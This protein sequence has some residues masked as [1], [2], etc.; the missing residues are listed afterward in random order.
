MTK[1]FLTAV[2]KG[3]EV[4]V[5]VSANH[6]AFE[7]DAGVCRSSAL[8]ALA[9]D[10]DTS[11]L[12]EGNGN[13]SFFYSADTAFALGVLR[14]RLEPASLR[15][16][17]YGH[18]L[19][20]IVYFWD[21]PTEHDVVAEA[22]R[23]HTF[24]RETWAVDQYLLRL[25]PV[26]TLTE[27]VECDGI[28]VPPGFDS[29]DEAM[30]L[31][32]SSSLKTAR[33]YASSYVR[34][35][36]PLLDSVAMT[37]ASLLSLLATLTGNSSA[38]DL[39]DALSEEQRVVVAKELASLTTPEAQLKRARM[40][41][42][43]AVQMAAILRNM[44]AQAFT[45]LPTILSSNYES[46]DYS[47]LGFGGSFLGYLALYEHTRNAFAELQLDYIVKNEFPTMTA[48]ALQ[49][50]RTSYPQWRDSLREHTG[51][52]KSTL[53]PPP[54]TGHHLLYFSNRL[55]FRET[56]LSMSAAYLSLRLGFLPSW[57]LFT[58]THEFMH[59][60]ARAFFAT[61]VPTAPEDFNAAYAA[62]AARSDRP[63]QSLKLKVFLQAMLLDTAHQLL[64]IDNGAG[65]TDGNLRRYAVVKAYP[66]KEARAF[67]RSS[68]HLLNE[69][70][71]SVLD[72]NYF[73]ANDP[74]LYVKS[75]WSSWLPLPIVFPRTFEYLLRTLC[76]ISSTRSGD[77]EEKFKWA[78]KVLDDALG[79]LREC[80]WVDAAALQVVL[81]DLAKNRSQLRLN[82]FCWCGYVD[83]V[84]RFLIS[85]KAKVHLLTDATAAEQEDG[86]FA[87]DLAP[88]QFETRRIKSPLSFLMDVKRRA[89]SRVEPV[90]AE[91]SEAETLWMFHFLAS[92]LVN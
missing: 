37:A 20:S 58:F 78:Y 9:A 46:G 4:R 81:N 12:R 14:E 92:A 59:A 75:V 69:I 26:N 10:A 44:N 30:F 48:P 3:R 54:D 56:K 25:P 51:V 21:N 13:I 55:G 38:T 84:V 62:Y 19:A 41:R 57:T 31:E 66:P 86:T 24:G 79:S 52:D 28:V 80:P 22:L 63:A 49:A 65:N 71:T 74:S 64:S 45:G 16:V 7:H 76:A 11:P 33:A 88:L 39:Q 72:F 70:A 34:T 2:V 47:L 35:Y 1:V 87:Y 17:F 29:A 15:R 83:V 40:V 32:L 42:D 85:S 77:Q 6:P 91:I 82:F 5:R 73:Y 68:Y 8:Y 61:V 90:P 67:L 53:L 36:L 18:G 50:D 43:E 23:D 27:P 89:L 60:H